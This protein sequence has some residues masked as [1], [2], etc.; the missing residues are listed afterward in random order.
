MVFHCSH[1]ITSSLP[2]PLREP[3]LALFG[4]VL[5]PSGSQSGPLGAILDDFF[6]LECEDDENMCENDDIGMNEAPS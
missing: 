5:A 2:E 3:L 4:V 1:F 6:V